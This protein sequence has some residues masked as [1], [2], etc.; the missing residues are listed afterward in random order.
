HVPPALVDRENMG[1]SVPIAQW[2]AGPLRNRA[3]D[4]L[5]SGESEGLRR[6]TVVRREWDRFLAG[7]S[8]NAP[9]IWAVVMFRAWQNRW[10]GSQADLGFTTAP[11]QKKTGRII[12]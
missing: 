1:C 11:P 4:L 9:G 2:L 5:L 10:L 12:V 3:G 7:D 8:T 6:S